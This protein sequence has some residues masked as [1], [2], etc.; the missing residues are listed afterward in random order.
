[1]NNSFKRLLS[2]VLAVMM[3]IS[4]TNFVAAY[5]PQTADS[6]DEVISGSAVGI[7]MSDFSANPV[8]GYTEFAPDNDYSL[9]IDGVATPVNGYYIIGNVA[10]LG[11]N[12]SLPSISISQ[13]GNDF[14]GES[15]DKVAVFNKA[16]DQ[17]GNFIAFAVDE[18]A[19]VVVYSQPNNQ[20]EQGYIGIQT[21]MPG[22]TVTEANLDI[23]SAAIGD[24]ET[25]HRFSVK[26]AGQ[27]A[28][29]ATT[30]VDVAKVVVIPE[31]YYGI[32]TL[33]DSEETDNDTGSAN[34]GKG[35][36]DA[37]KNGLDAGTKVTF[38]DVTDA[39]NGVYFTNYGS[40]SAQL[41]SDVASKYYLL[42]QPNVTGNLTFDVN[43]DAGCA[44]YDVTSCGNLGALTSDDLGT[45]IRVTDSSEALANVSFSVTKDHIYCFLAT[46]GTTRLG[47]VTLTAT[48]TPVADT[49][50]VSVDATSV[51]NGTVTLSA[52]GVAPIVLNSTTTSATVDITKTWTVTATANDGYELTGLTYKVGDGEATDLTTSGGTLTG[53][54]KDATV[55]ITPVF[56]ETTAP[57]VEK[58]SI[59]VDSAASVTNGTVT[60]SDGTTTHTLNGTD[61][62]SVDITGNWVVT[63]TPNADYDLIS[64]KYTVNGGTATDLTSGTALPTLNANDV[65][66]IT[67]VFTKITYNASVT[68]TAG[69]NGAISSITDASGNAVT[70]TNDVYTLPAGTYTVNTTPA[71]NYEFDSITVTGSDK[72]TVSG[73]TIT[74][75]DLTAD[76]TATATVSFKDKSTTTTGAVWLVT[77]TDTTN[78]NGLNL[79]TNSS[80]GSLTSDRTAT[81]ADNIFDNGTSNV[82]HS[83]TYWAYNSNAPITF[84]APANGKVYLYVLRP[85]T[86]TNTGTVS[87]NGTDVGQIQPRNATDI[88]ALEIAVTANTEYNVAAN[89]RMALYGIKYVTDGD[90]PIVPTTKYTVSGTITDSDGATVTDTLTIKLCEGDS[91][92]TAKW[93]VT[94]TKLI[95]VMLLLFLQ[96]ALL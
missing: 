93:T 81:F 40:K 79:T 57:V 74:V 36:L 32:S 17:D 58:A 24:K 51:A 2:M 27:Y 59:N 92:S 62:V 8:L 75:A 18:P 86:N 34:A 29:A 26:E 48:D 88:P 25:I 42:I 70:G 64:L 4:S 89:T 13:L 14:D 80:T 37:L 63:A 5:T 16:S 72:V 6:A 55:V 15:F 78:L 3:C 73:S 66:V 67:P 22:G 53:L 39:T 87:V 54:T 45:A 33:V 71:D 50:T 46:T 83:R 10:L 76:V 69:A 43:Q 1:M 56:T 84:T 94:A 85:D 12:N 7:E 9:E 31:S 96:I 44:M 61:A 21:G 20:D 28:I 30:S 41:K 47:S 35:T 77:D 68:I 11:S 19:E 95:Q 60:I 65:V 91:T 23:A 52:D 82:A 90:T 38:S 49:A